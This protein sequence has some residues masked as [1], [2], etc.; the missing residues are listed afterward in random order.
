ML[1]QLGDLLESMLK[2]AYDA[3]DSGWIFPGHGG[4]L[5]GPTAWFC[6]SCSFTTMLSSATVYFTA[7]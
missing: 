3:K 4:V 5:T 2:R 7:F 6:R 1:A